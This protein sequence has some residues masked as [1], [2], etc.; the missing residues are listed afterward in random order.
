[1]SVV[2]VT[3]K[4]ESYLDLTFA[5]ATELQELRFCRVSPTPVSGRWRIADVRKVG[6]AAIAGCEVRVIPKTPIENIVYMSSLGGMQL[7]LGTADVLFGRE[8]SVPEAIV[9]AFLSAV[10]SAT[11]SGLLKGYRSAEESSPVVRGRWNIARQLAARPG[12]PLPVEVD[13]DEFT[14]DIAE[15]RILVTALG[16]VR[17]LP[18]LS[19]N[20]RH[21]LR[22]L[23]V[24]FAEVSS[25]PRGQAL[26]EVRPDRLNAHYTVAL[27]LAKAILDAVSWTHREGTV[28]GATF[29]VDMAA[30]FERYVANRLAVALAG[31]GLEVAAQ[32]QEWWL[33]TGRSVSL[34]PDIVI[35][36]RGAPVAVADTKYKVLGSGGGAPPNGDVYQA[37][38]YAMAI[39]VS[40][41]HLIY[42]ADDVDARVIDVPFVGVRVYVHALPLAGS[43]AWLDR[44]VR[45][46]AGSLSHGIM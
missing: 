28:V 39:G 25:L 21:A 36:R 31:D 14:E 8:A 27:R 23:Q 18:G 34:R 12:I 15:N 11:R 29:L 44:A 26:P 4:G 7:R 3:E 30:V 1:V 16:V 22:A 41:A 24:V 37:V 43:V 13:Y 45:E 42:T 38:A 32:A 19:D 33:D 10:G 46:L 6:V 9:D 35:S 40:S 17:R 5:Q 20:A 2:F